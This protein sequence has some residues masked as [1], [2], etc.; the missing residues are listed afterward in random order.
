ME[1]K[2]G[3]C[4]IVNIDAQTFEQMLSK[5]E[6]FAERM[7]QLCRLHGDKDSNEWLDNQDV[8]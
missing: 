3:V 7:E 8:L 1:T 6:R 5:F 2:F 4:Q